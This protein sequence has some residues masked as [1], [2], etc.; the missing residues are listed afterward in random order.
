[1]ISMKRGVLYGAVLLVMLMRGPGAVLAQREFP[2]TI[3]LSPLP[4]GLEDVQYRSIDDIIQ[5]GFDHFWVYHFTGQGMKEV[6]RYAQSRGMSFDY[7]TSGFEGFDRY[8]APATSVYAPGYASEVRRRVDSGLAPLKSAGGLYSVY[9]FQDEP[10]HA[11][12]ASFDF[13][14]DAKT[15]FHKRYG[16]AMPDSLGAVR[17][18]PRKWLDLLNFQSNCFRD[19]WKQVYHA[20]KELLPRVKVV[21]THDSHN[22]FGAGVRSNS[23]VAMDDVFHWG[24]DFADVLAYDIY[25]YLTFDYRYG[26]LG[27][28]PKPR[29]SQLHYTIAQMRNLSSSYGK[30]L[31]FWVGTYSDNWFQ[32]FKGAERKHQYWSE[33]EISLTAIAQGANYI[34]SP[35]NFNATNLPMDSLHWEGYGQA[36][37][38]VRKVGA[39]LLA[40]PRVKARACFLFPRTQYLQLQQEYYNVGL[41]YELFFRAFG[42][43]DILHEEQITDDRLNGYKVLVLADVELL[44]AEVA[45]HI[46]HFV[47][48]GGVVI[49]DC[50]PQMD[51][52]KRPLNVMEK[53]FGVGKA[54]TARIHRE[55]QWVPFTALPPKMSFPPAVGVPE[56]GRTDMLQGTAFGEAFHF[57]VVSPRGCKVTNG[58]VRLT[59]GAGGPALVYRKVGKGSAYLF[60]FC[61]QDSYF[62]TWKDNDTAGR[63]QLRALIGDVFA[64]AGIRSHIYSSNPD[65]EASVRANDAGGYVFVIN[66]ESSCPTSS[67][68]LEGLGFTVGKIVDVASGAEVPFEKRGAAVEFNI[69]AALGET[70]LLELKTIL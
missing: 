33:R 10:F 36:M 62:N 22:V 8:K 12:P 1:M 18:D 35:S 6:I 64:E 21:M 53:V 3:Q 46:A 11:G 29:I 34:I 20:V 31:G 4:A 41:S 28:L 37:K 61:M 51:A 45:R 70:R 24:G 38:V 19:G 27:K 42:E 47:R 2:A 17:N 40:A 48:N 13:S 54:E 7:M 32:R 69:D 52:Y 66:H 26:E 5:H 49:A 68:R 65:I 23:T 43:L 55:G 44:P 39:G 14:N 63:R 58:K 57:G 59:L 60:G 15:E 16:Y 30:D 25:P 56:L 9:P 67:V 50:V